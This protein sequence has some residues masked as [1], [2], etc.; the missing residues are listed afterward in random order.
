MT[1]EP[2]ATEQDPTPPF[3]CSRSIS[4]IAIALAKAQGELA[5]PTKDKTAKVTSDKGNYTYNYADLAS[6][7]AVIRPVLSKHEIALVQPPVMVGPGRLEVV[8]TLI[9]KS[10]EWIASSLGIDITDKRPQSVGI[11]I[12]YLRRYQVQSLVG[13]ASEEDDDAG[14]TDV[15][16]SGRGNGHG[17]QDDR[18]RHRQEN[19]ASTARVADQLREQK[20]DAAAAAD[21]GAQ[22]PA[23]TEP[24]IPSDGVYTIARIAH[25]EKDAGGNPVAFAIF[26]DELGDQ[27]LETRDLGIARAIFNVKKA[28]PDDKSKRRMV[29]DWKT[30]DGHRVIEQLGPAPAAGAAA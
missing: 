18:Q 26:T 27:I 15:V 21:P 20:R 8:T 13:V 3:Q 10:G 2:Q 6:V 9:H 1:G 12:T 25:L 29:I 5:N 11:A 7:L 23:P 30:V 28:H 17:R 4:Q 19:A 16:M 24:T 22:A 14:S